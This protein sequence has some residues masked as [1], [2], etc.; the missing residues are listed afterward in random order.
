MPNLCPEPGTKASMLT[1]GSCVK[2]TWAELTPQRD[3]REAK[4][5]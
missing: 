5:C 4:P 1:P 2:A 3:W